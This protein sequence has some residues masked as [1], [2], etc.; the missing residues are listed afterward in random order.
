MTEEEKCLSRQQCPPGQQFAN[1]TSSGQYVPC[2]PSSRGSCTI[3]YAC[4]KMC[5]EDRIN[6]CAQQNMVCDPYWGTA[7][8]CT[9]KPQ[10][11]IYR[12]APSAPN[13]TRNECVQVNMPKAWCT[14]KG[15]QVPS[16]Q[17]TYCQNAYGPDSKCEYPGIK[18]LSPCGPDAYG[19]CSGAPEADRGSYS[20]TGGENRAYMDAT[21][22]EDC[23]RSG[24]YIGI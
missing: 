23:P 13:P 15:E 20:L 12:C 4:R 21:C 7:A 14:P 11:H 18:G 9:D 5:S 10:R 8:E 1:K 24:Q 6:E 22:N 3:P 2:E 17:Q 19:Y 16:G